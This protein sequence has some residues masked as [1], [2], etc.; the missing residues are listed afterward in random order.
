MRRLKEDYGERSLQGLAQRLK[1]MRG[2][3]KLYRHF[4]A[5]LYLLGMDR[6]VVQRLCAENDE[7][8][9]QRVRELAKRAAE[10]GDV[11]VAVPGVP[12]H[13]PMELEYARSISPSAPDQV[14]FYGLENFWRK[15]T[16]PSPYALLVAKIGLYFSLPASERPAVDTVPEFSDAEQWHSMLR[17]LIMLALDDGEALPSY[18]PLPLARQWVGELSLQSTRAALATWLEFHERIE[19]EITCQ[20]HAAVIKELMEQ[21]RAGHSIPLVVVAD[22]VKAQK[23]AHDVGDGMKMG[24]TWDDVGL[25]ALDCSVLHKSTPETCKSSMVEIKVEL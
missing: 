6:A 10:V 1:L 2:P 5:P 22:G 13:R 17:D 3:S 24:R 15:C 23:V 19:E 7:G 9:R 20:A 11:A 16:A 21:T 14:P 18:F 4:T 25:D 8:A 12:H